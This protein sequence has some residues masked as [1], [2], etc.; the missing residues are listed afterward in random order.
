MHDHIVILG[1]GRLGRKIADKLDKRSVSYIAVEHDIRN[2]SEGQ[3]NGKNVI[4]G[5]AA[6]KMMLESLNVTDAAVIIVALD[7]PEK[8]HLICDVLKHMATKA[9]VVIKVDRFIDKEHLK[10]EF[11]DYEILVGTEQMARGMVDSVLKCHIS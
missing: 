4:F 7:N 2:V 1:Y 10:D 3:K 8:L 5:N 11:P 6:S 9:K